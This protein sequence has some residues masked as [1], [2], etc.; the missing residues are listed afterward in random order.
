M[1][2]TVTR[3]R[4]AFPKSACSDS[5]GR[6]V[7]TGLAGDGLLTTAVKVRPAGLLPRNTPATTKWLILH[8]PLRQTIPTLVVECRMQNPLE[9]E[10]DGGGDCVTV[11]LVWV[12]GPIA[13]CVNE[14]R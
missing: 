6:P 8:R 9:R 11:C 13:T 4:F 7:S 1:I 14:A 12:E 2:E 3:A 10:L 5:N